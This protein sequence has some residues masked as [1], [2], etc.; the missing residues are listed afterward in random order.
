M[1]CVLVTTFQA[2][3]PSLRWSSDAKARATWNGSPKLVETV[4]PSPMWRVTVLS[5]A[6]S[7]IGSNRLTND[8]MVAGIHRQAVGD[9]E[10]VEFAALGDARDRLH[11]RQAAAARGGA[12]VAPAG[13]MV[14]GAEH[15]HAEMHLTL[16][17]GHDAGVFPA[18]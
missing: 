15:E 9:E 3:R 13:R 6:S 17:I 11:H 7:V 5:A 18:Y 2:A 4:A 16:A 12:F 1:S 14:A 10:Q 8:G